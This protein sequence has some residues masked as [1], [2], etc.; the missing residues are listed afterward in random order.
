M[1]DFFFPAIIY[2][3]KTVGSGKQNKSHRGDT[4]QIT[5]DHSELTQIRENPQS[6]RDN[7]RQIYLWKTQKLVQISKK[8]KP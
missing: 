5:T 7:P 6:I 2:E 3:P 1:T 8:N 4:A